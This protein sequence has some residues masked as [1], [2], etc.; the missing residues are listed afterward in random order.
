[1]APD[2]APGTSSTMTSGAA[3]VEEALVYSEKTIHPG[4]YSLVLNRPNAHNSLSRALLSQMEATL[5]ELAARCCTSTNSSR[6]GSLAP[7]VAASTPIKTASSVSPRS[8]SPPTANVQNVANP[9]AT[10]PSPPKDPLLVLIIRSSSPSKFC[11]GADLKERK[12]MSE[13]EVVAFLG[14]LRRVFDKVA[15]FPVPTIAA[16]DGPA[17]GGGLE[18]AIACDFRV[19][20]E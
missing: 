3:P 5:D 11:A 12:T 19:A 1:M 20:S 15:R 17:L 18:L 14:D 7:T 8:G 16:L 13:D 2:I 6:R 9:V 10:P 4:V